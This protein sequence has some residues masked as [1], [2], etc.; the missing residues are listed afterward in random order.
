[1]KNIAIF[2]LAAI[3]LFGCAGPQ[4]GT[5]SK[6]PPTAPTEPS[7]PSAPSDDCTPDYSFS[8]LKDGTFSQTET[9]VA[10]VTCAGNTTLNLKVD[11]KTVE[12]KTADSDVTT[13]LKF[14]VPALKEGTSKVTVET[15]NDSLFS[16]D[17]DVEA[18]G[19]T[20]TR[21]TGYEAFSYKTWVAMAFDIEN[22]VELGQ[23]KAFLK[24]QSGNTRPNSEL[25]LEVRKDS[26]GEPGSL[27]ASKG[28]AVTEPTLT[29][30][31]I[32]FDLDKKVSLS[33]GTYW[34]V[35]MVNQTEDLGLASDMVTVNYEIIDKEVEG[36]DYTSR[37]ML[38]VDLK[39]GEASETSW[40]PLSYDREFNIVLGYGK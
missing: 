38:D 26:S 19:N 7:V 3:L 23:V 9:L 35:L 1:M 16:R 28:M 5:P 25:V 14:S 2:L 21:G 34:V 31:W 22:P 32:K 29:E 18:L 33:P 39:T 24:R 6:T 27:L 15:A 17:W 40:E 11:G 4:P 36:N 13:P 37:M 8:V 10:T 30:N 20:D 12:S